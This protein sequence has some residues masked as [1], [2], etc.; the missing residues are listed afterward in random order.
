[1]VGGHWKRG[2]CWKLKAVLSRIQRVQCDQLGLLYKRAF[3]TRGSLLAPHSDSK[4]PACEMHEVAS[5]KQIPS[6]PA[7]RRRIAQSHVVHSHSGMTLSHSRDTSGKRTRLNFVGG[8]IC[9]SRR[10][11][12]MIWYQSWPNSNNCRAFDRLSGFSPSQSCEH[13]PSTLR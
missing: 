5:S 12:K 3:I 2:R 9:I 4:R 13:V 11:P 1:M 6:G 10:L 7:P 8:L